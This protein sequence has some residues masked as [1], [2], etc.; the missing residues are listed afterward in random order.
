MYF[1]LTSIYKKMQKKKNSLN[2]SQK[3]QFSIGSAQFKESLKEINVKWKKSEKT[4][5]TFF[6]S[7]RHCFT[8]Q[9]DIEEML[10][11]W[12][13]A[14]ST[15]W[16][17][18]YSSFIFRLHFIIPEQKNRLF[19]CPKFNGF[20]WRFTNDKCKWNVCGLTNPK[21]SSELLEKYSKVNF[22]TLSSERS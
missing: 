18:K 13:R 10:F 14:R 19:C 20:N 3:F 17:Q 1:L 15:R 2:R 9:S 5:K 22:V 6:V 8:F 7:K 12:I 16:T 4:E 11:I 21:T